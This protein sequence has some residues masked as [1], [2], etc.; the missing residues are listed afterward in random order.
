MAVYTH[1]II[2]HG[3]SGKFGRYSYFRQRNGRT[4]FCR[5]E[6]PYTGPLSD[7]QVA[8]NNKFRQAHLFAQSVIGNPARKA[9][10]ARRARKG[11]S[12]YNEAISDAMQAPEIRHLQEHNRMIRIVAIDNFEVTQVSAELYD[13]TGVLIEKGMATR[14][15]HADN[16]RYK[17]KTKNAAR[18]VIKAFDAAGNVAAQEMFTEGISTA[19]SLPAKTFTDHTPGKETRIA[20]FISKPGN[21]PP[22]PHADN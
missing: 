7:K 17:V 11:R 14:S 21:P 19:S 6:N 15:N 9:S 8:S 18:V 3:L 13:D 5:I 10:Y 1:N 16:W 4:H 12:A 20:V 2:T 22:W